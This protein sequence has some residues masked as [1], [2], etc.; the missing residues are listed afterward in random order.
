MG[1][2]FEQEWWFKFCAYAAAFVRLTAE[3]RVINR[4]NALFAIKPKNQ[5]FGFLQGYIRAGVLMQAQFV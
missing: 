2:V 5:S 3:L 1:L 4:L